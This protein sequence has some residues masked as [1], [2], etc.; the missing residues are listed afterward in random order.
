LVYFFKV[1][2]VNN[3]LFPTTKPNQK[4]KKK[5][6]RRRRKEKKEEG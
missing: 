4:K 1:N 2:K 6:R 3:Y 5:N